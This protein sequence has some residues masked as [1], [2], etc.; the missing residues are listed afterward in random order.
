MK[1]TNAISLADGAFS[2]LTLR[3]FVSS[4]VGLVFN[5]PASWREN[6]DSEYFQ[7]VDPQTGMQVT[8]SAYRNP[9]MPLQQW[10]DA[11]L[12]T[13]EQ[14]M[15]FLRLVQ[16][17]R[18]MQGM[19]WTGIVGEY[20][21]VFPQQQRE[22]RYLVL[23]LQTEAL[24]LS[25]TIVADD[26]IFEENAALY[27]WLL[28]TQL[29]LYVVVKI[30]EDAQG[31]EVLRQLAEQGNPNARFRLAAL[32]EAGN[33]VPQ[34]FRLAAEWYRQAAEQWRALVLQAGIDSSEL[35]PPG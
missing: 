16:A 1:P 26:R 14:A 8:V 3:R 9:G 19:A 34:D 13:I 5:A 23:C 29:D 15:P 12:G 10:A 33:G 21:G 6:P 30:Q 4:A 24:L 18:E 17:P 35:H 31:V 22:S 27:R 2:G 28:Q 25:V 32:Y 7:I 11:R 20:Q